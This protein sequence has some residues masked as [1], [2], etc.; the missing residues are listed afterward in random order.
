L[1]ARAR[2]LAIGNER[3]EALALLDKRL[4]DHPDDTDARTLYG[5]ILSWEGCYD[6]ARK[7]LESVLGRNANHG[8]AL[9]FGL[10]RLAQDLLIRSRAMAALVV[11]HA[12]NG[13]RI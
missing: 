2:S 3:V 10:E 4:A 6:D 12:G 5:I 8:D 1:I 11:R 9:L 7:A 13:P